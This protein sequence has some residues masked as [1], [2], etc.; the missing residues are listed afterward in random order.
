MSAIRSPTTMWRRSCSPAGPGRHANIYDDLRRAAAFG[1]VL[2]KT[3]SRS[4]N[5]SASRA[6]STIGRRSIRANTRQPPR[7]DCGANPISSHVDD[8]RRDVIDNVPT[9]CADGLIAIALTES[10]RRTRQSRP[11]ARAVINPW[12]FPVHASL[13]ASIRSAMLERAPRKR[14]TSWIPDV[15]GCGFAMFDG[16]AAPAAAVAARR[17]ADAPQRA[18]GGDRSAKRRGGIQSLQDASRP[19]H[20]GFAT[21]RLSRR[22]HGPPLCRRHATTPTA[23]RG[24]KRKCSPTESKSRASD[25]LVGEITSHGRLLDAGGDLLARFTQA[26]R[27]VRGLPAAIVDVE[28]DSQ[29]LPEGDIWSSY[30]A[31]R[32]AWSDDAL[33]VRRGVEWIGRTTTG[34][35]GSSRPSGS[36]SPT[37]SAR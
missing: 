27:L 22:A 1:P 5:I 9:V 13:S 28:L 23:R 25:D 6:R 24:S 4:K 31:S 34:A 10:I 30:F 35:N 26:V 19:A 11:M 17:R 7:S 37:A 18:S 29:R 8:Y 12:N 32:L 21:A 14:S 16:N 36:K 20:A 2:G 33:S 15:P 3:R